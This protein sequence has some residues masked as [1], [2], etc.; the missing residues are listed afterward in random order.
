M[1]FY[2]VLVCL[3][4]GFLVFILNPVLE[5]LTELDLRLTDG[6]TIRKSREE[7]K[8]HLDADWTKSLRKKKQNFDCIAYFLECTNSDYCE[9]KCNNDG[10]TMYD[11]V[12]NKCVPVFQDRAADVV[13]LDVS[14][15]CPRNKGL[16]PYLVADFAISTSSWKCLSLTSK[17]F[18]DNG[19][20]APGICEN[21][22]LTVD[23]DN[24]PECICPENTTKIEY[25]SAPRCVK[26]PVL[27]ENL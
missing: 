4:I 7:F 10:I 20:N 9:N 19:L 6:G 24:R 8:S 11:C 2:V 1:L 3:C 21:G 25:D 17:Y 14:K 18:S 15:K 26:Y 23:D 22:T 27:F 12:M 5:T 16:Y 13:G